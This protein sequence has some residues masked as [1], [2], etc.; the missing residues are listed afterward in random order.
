MNEDVKIQWNNK[1]LLN[2]FDEKVYRHLSLIAKIKYNIRKN[3]QYLRE[4]KIK[5]GKL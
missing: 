4:R 5:N 3:I 1:I 2:F